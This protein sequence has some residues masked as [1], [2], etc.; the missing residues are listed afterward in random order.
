[1]C[2]K[3]IIFPQNIEMDNK[4]SSCISDN[5]LMQLK[6]RLVE[7]EKLLDNTDANNRLTVVEAKIQ[8]SVDLTDDIVGLSGNLL[9]TAEARVNN[10]LLHANMVLEHADNL[11]DVYLVSIGFLIAIGSIVVTLF[12]GKKQDEQ[13]KKSIDEITRKLQ[14]DEKFRREF[15]QLIMEDENIQENLDYEMKEAVKNLVKKNTS[16][17]ST[18]EFGNDLFFQK[19]KV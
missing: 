11:V 3:N 12:L 13:V 1:M 19:N 7:V 17:G 10:A 16:K 6:E 4:L 8:A 18:K 14:K 2:S 5:E 15:I 9:E